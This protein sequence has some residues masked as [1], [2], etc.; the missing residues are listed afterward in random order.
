M[1]LFIQLLVHGFVHRVVGSTH[2]SCAHVVVSPTVALPLVRGP[3]R[4]RKLSQAIIEYQQSERENSRHAAYFVK[5]QILA[6][7]F[8][9]WINHW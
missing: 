3:V 2:Y 8:H 4:S 6:G 5:L 1:I 7:G 9:G